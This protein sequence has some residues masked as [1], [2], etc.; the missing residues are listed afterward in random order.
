VHFSAFHPDYRML[1][2]PRT[3]PETLIAAAA[4]AKRIGLHHVYTG[5]IHH[6][7]TDT[8]YC[9]GCGTALIERDWYRLTGWGLGQGG[10]CRTCGTALPGRF[11]D[12]PGTWGPKRQ[13]VRL[14]P[15]PAAREA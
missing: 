10:H 1:D 11:E 4:T 7:P 13:P 9:A 3:P 6:P 5:N 8:T 15:Q 2:V 12:S 14:A